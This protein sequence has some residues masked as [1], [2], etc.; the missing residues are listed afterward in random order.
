MILDDVISAVAE[1]RSPIVLTERRDHLEHLAARLL[2]A[3]DRAPRRHAAK[4]DVR[5]YDYVDGEVPLL[6]RMVRKRLRGYR[7]LGYIEG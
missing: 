1:G 5:I 4:K 7:A 2:P 3:P 6:A